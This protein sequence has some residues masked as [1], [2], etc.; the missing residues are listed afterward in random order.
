MADSATLALRLAGPLQS[1]GTSSRYNQRETDLLP[2][3]SGI[4]GLLAAAQG[5]RR[6]DSIA[7]LLGL[8]LSIRADQPGTLL[9][10]FHTVSTVDGTPLLSASVN[11]KGKQK[12]TSPKKF[13]HVTNRFYLQDAVFVAL[14][15]GSPAL[16]TDLADALRRPRFFLSLGRRSC[17]PSQPL[18]I[19]D[20]DDDLFAASSEELARTLPWQA[21]RD[22][23]IRR[24]AGHTVTVAATFE[25]AD[26][27][28]TATDVPVSFEPRS[29]GFKSRRVRHEWI[30]LPTGKTEESAKPHDPF[31]LLGW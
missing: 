11:T 20:G 23:P 8:T 3:K 1:W 17:P 18:I 14:L 28:T 16:L 30:P 21:G 22:H 13:T 27:M 26:G 25:D 31:A 19:T 7:D 2:S 4:I 6:V 29:R 12:T 9:R 5:R 15:E 24:Q 10:D